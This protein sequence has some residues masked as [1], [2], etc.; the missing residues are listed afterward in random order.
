MDRVWRIDRRTPWRGRVDTFKHYQAPYIRAVDDPAEPLREQRIGQWSLIPHFEKTPQFAY[1][2]YNAKFEDIL[3]KKTKSFLQPWAR[4]QRCLIPAEAYYESCWETG[5]SQSWRFTR[6]DGQL[7]GLAGLW[8]TWHD[9]V[10][11]VSCESFT[12][13]T[14]NADAH[15]LM[16]RMHKPDDKLPADQQDK[17]MVVPIEVADVDRW[18]SGQVDDVIPLVRMAPQQ[19]FVSEPMPVAPKRPKP[20]R[21][22]KK[23]LQEQP[24]QQGELF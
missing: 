18:L 23:Q 13:L 24:P 15:P 3:S 20:P 1:D 2:T 12:M 17:R 21:S 11:G 6:A 19:L 16:S 10:S 7:W 4:G 14:I 5:Q 9:P 22:V 8:N